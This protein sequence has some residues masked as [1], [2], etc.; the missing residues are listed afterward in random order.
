MAHPVYIY[1]SIVF[2]CIQLL[3]STGIGMVNGLKFFVHGRLSD[4]SIVQILEH[5]ALVLEYYKR[6]KALVPD[7]VASELDQAFR[8]KKYAVLNST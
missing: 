3:E 8:G 6:S 2:C 4:V 1:I 7:I 5:N